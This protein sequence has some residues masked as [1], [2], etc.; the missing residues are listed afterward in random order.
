MKQLNYWNNLN[1]EYREDVMK[2]VT[3]KENRCWLN[4]KYHSRP[5]SKILYDLDIAEKLQ[6]KNKGSD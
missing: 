5:L 6:Q 4:Q 2:V 3:N 1:I